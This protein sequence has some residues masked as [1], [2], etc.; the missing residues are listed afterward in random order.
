MEMLL[1]GNLGLGQK[2]VPPT[3]AQDE[4]VAISH[5]PVRREVFSFCHS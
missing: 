5:S 4:T 1:Y 2:A 3:Y